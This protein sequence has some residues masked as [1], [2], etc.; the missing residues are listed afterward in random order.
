MSDRM[1]CSAC[2]LQRRRREELPPQPHHRAPPP[3]P[4]P[5]LPSQTALHKLVQQHWPWLRGLLRPSP[6]Q[7]LSEG[8]TCEGRAWN[9]GS[10]H[11]SV[12]I[13]L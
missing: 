12:S 11:C 3:H 5:Q 6:S 13:I 10:L 9:A 1:S 7:Q 2:G 8:A 4:R